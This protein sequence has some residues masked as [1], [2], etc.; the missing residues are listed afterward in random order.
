MVKGREAPALGGAG[1]NPRSA[2]GLGGGAGPPG[3]SFPS[4]PLPCTLN[5]LGVVMTWGCQSVLTGTK[6]QRCSPYQ[7]WSPQ[8]RTAPGSRAPHRRTQS[9][10]NSEMRGNPPDTK[11]RMVKANPTT[12]GS[13]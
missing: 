11:F 3:P 5:S 10:R 12:G 8:P 7:R 2:L 9:I 4:S 1:S 13:T 6:P